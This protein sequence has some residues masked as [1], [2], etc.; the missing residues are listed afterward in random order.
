MS[1]LR[2]IAGV[3]ALLLSGVAA[4]DVESLLVQAGGAAREASYRGVVV[5][6]DA[7]ATEVLRVSHQV[8]GGQVSERLTTLTG[9]PRTLSREGGALACALPGRG[10]RTASAGA[11]Q[12]VLTQAS[13]T[14]AQQH[15]ELR[16]TGPG[17]IAGRPCR[18]VALLPRDAF[19]YGYEICADA[20]T[21]VPLR[22]GLT[23]SDGHSLESLVFTEIE[24]APGSPGARAAAP[25]PHH[26]PEAPA[27][28]AWSFG[29]LPPG[30]AVASRVLLPARHGAPPVEHVMLSDGLAAISVFAEP[31][32]ADAAAEGAS[33]IGAVSVFV[34]RVD[35][36][37]LTVIGEVPDAAVRAVADG[38]VVPGGTTV[39]GGR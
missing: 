18:G 33:R 15:Y 14:A 6:H 2:G 39:A 34:R 16:D 17:R 37:H 32:A 4:A 31:D 13:L 23:D 29:A 12:P 7:R 20:A 19:R 38:L 25:R 30:Y 21:A 35:G 28:S 36:M 10:D 24:F 8:S 27:S 5:Y 1:G 26:R 22:V 11:A 9:A 3:V